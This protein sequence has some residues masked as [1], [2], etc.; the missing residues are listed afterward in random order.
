MAADPSGPA[1]AAPVVALAAASSRTA[2]VGE[3]TDPRNAAGR[4]GGMLPTVLVA[5]VCFAVV[6]EF[7]A[8][9]LESGRDPAI[10][11]PSVA[12]TSQKVRPK[13]K[14][15]ITKVIPAGSGP[16]GQTTSGSGGYAAAPAPVVSSSS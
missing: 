1:P 3:M 13:K 5:A 12:A 9:Q 11:N 14:I 16:A 8:M 4:R 7:L 10:G 15:I 2:A 6:F